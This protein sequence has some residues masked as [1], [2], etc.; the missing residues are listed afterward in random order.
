MKVKIAIAGS[1]FLVGVILFMP[2]TMDLFPNAPTVIDSIKKDVTGIQKDAFNQV[3]D[4]IDKSVSSANNQIDNIKESSEGFLSTQGIPENI[5]PTQFEEVFFGKIKEENNPQQS[6][7]RHGNGNS[8]N[9]VPA[10]VPI[11]TTTPQTQT[12]SY[13]TLSLVTEKEGTENVMMKYIDTSGQTNSVTVTMRTTED[14]IL[15]TGQF[16]SSNFEATVLDAGDVAYFIDMVVDHQEFGTIS[17]S[18]FNPGNS[19]SMISGVF[20]ET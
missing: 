6:V 15:F 3:E 18:A 8:R 16:F 19:E 9:S 2:Q 17:A 10:G 1:I 4:G 12:I 13:E 5:I 11:V 20:T 7:K 14:V